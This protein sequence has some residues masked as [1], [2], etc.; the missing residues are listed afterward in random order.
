MG[1]YSFCCTVHFCKVAKCKY[2]IL[3]CRMTKLCAALS[4]SRVVNKLL[5]AKPSLTEVYKYLF[6]T[7]KFPARDFHMPAIL[8]VILIETITA[9]SLN[10]IQP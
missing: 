5:N 6:L 10:N 1:L 2:F 4:S 9:R 8:I 3:S 7:S